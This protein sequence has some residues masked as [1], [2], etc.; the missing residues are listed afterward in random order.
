MAQ[1][2][3]GRSADLNDYPRALVGAGLAAATV[4]ATL[5]LVR[6]SREDGDRPNIS[7]APDHV[8]RDRPDPNQI[9]QTI[10]VNVPCKDLYDRWRDFGRF[11]EFMDIVREVVKLD[12]QRSRWTIEAPLGSTVE[13]VTR[14]TSDEPGRLIAWESEPE[15]KI[16]TSGRV[17]FID[18][19][20]GRGTFVRL[21]MSYKP[22]AG[23]VG[24]GLA[25]LF[26]REPNLQARRDLRRFKQL[27][28]TGE[29][30]TN[31]SPSARKS[32]NPTEAR[33]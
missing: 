4:V 19:P 25:K 6:K 33:I 12:E 8:L 10:T 30:T 18:A 22:P 17:E 24:K 3:T 29:V 13:L 14:I 28:E 1:G 23:I 32:E 26:Q 11:P 31:A 16:R 21:T 9:G 27:M 7:D 5:L 2:R 15:S 20:P